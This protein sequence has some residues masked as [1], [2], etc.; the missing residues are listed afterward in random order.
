MRG[1]RRAL[2][3]AV[4]AVALLVP[5]AAPAGAATILDGYCS[6]SG[7]Y[8]TSVVKKV[9]G[10]IVF[11]IR[12]FANY[13]GQAEACVRRTSRVCHTVHAREDNHGLFIWAI[14]WQD[15]Y[16]NQGPGRYNVTWRDKSSGARIGP[17]LHF[18]RG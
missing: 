6:P 1:T 10:A 2:V 4:L 9:S 11:K 18:M 5:M 16:P 14:R 7:D 13:F 17:R 15:N 8:C 3:P 12:A